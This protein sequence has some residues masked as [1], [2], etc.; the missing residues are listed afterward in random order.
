MYNRPQA[1]LKKTLCKGGEGALAMDF[2][3]AV[4]IIIGLQALKHV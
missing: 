1:K 3:K 4:D 2:H